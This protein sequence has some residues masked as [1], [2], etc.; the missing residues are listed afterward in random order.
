MSEFGFPLKPHNSKMVAVSLLG[1]STFILYSLLLLFF[2][3]CPRMLAE[4][5]G[6]ERLGGFVLSGK[7]D[8][9]GNDAPLWPAI[10]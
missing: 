9:S 5:E 10:D 6:G 1:R 2:V 3:K 7:C 4:S 8:G